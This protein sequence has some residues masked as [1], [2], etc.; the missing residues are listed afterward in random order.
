MREPCAGVLLEKLRE[1]DHLGDPDLDRRIILMW[2]FKKWDMG[3]WTR[4]RIETVAGTCECGNESL[5]SVKCGE[6][7][8]YLSNG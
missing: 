3:V 2:L 1:R 7:L 6:F 8:D 4:L 5:D